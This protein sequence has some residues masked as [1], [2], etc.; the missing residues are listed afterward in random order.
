MRDILDSVA[1]GDLSPTE[2]EA[3]LS[4]YATSGAGRF[5][6]AREDRAGVPEA[7]LADGKTPTEVADLAATAIETTDRAIVTR[8]DT[9]TATAVRERLDKTAPDATVRW[10]DRSNWLVA[11]T[12]AFERP[13]LD[14]SVGIVTAGTS[15]AVPAGEAALIVE[16]MG[17]TVTRID[18]VGVASLARTIDAVDGLREQD[19]LIV[20]AGREGALPTVVAGL[21]DVPVIGLPV[22]TGYGHGGE[23]EAALSGLLQSCT[24]LSVVNIDAGFTAG[25]QAGLIARQLDN[26]RE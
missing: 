4:G 15:D 13:S 22:S 5:D 6:A 2:A 23:G 19:V 25:T 17:A 10:D 26:A 18:D 12:P 24:A 3:A 1:A 8:L 9:S 20:A 11:T 7:V 14:A 21:V 16:E